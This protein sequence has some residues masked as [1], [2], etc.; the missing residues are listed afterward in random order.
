MEALWHK[1]DT[2]KSGVLEKHGKKDEF[3]ALV[4]DLT[5]YV[6]DE[7]KLKL[8]ANDIFKLPDGFRETTHDWI[9]ATLDANGDGKCSKEEFLQAI[10]KILNDTDEGS[11]RRAHDL[12]TGRAA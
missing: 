2:D 8:E 10:E 4:K 6:E 5:K 3:E 9:K 1:Y 11:S 7:L 12:R